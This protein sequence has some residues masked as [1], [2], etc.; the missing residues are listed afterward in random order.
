MGITFL[1]AGTSIPD[2]YASIHVAKMVI[3][4]YLFL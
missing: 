2:A 3:V 1:A 4:F